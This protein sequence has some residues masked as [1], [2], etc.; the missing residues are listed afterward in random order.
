MRKAALDT[1]YGL[2]QKDSRVVFIGSDLGAGTLSE[3]AETLPDRFFMEGIAE[4]HLI[5]MAAGMALEGMIPYVNTIA[6]FLTR[7]C[8]EQ[9]A[10]DLCLHKLPVRLIANGGGLVYAPLGPTHQAI[11]DFALMRALP[12]MTCVAPADAVEMRKLMVNSLEWPGPVYFRLGKGGDP[13]ITPDDDS[14]EIGKAY[15]MEP[16]IGDILMIST[17]I[18][19]ER[20]L[21]ALKLSDQ[22]GL[23]VG[24]VHVPTI[25][26]LDV[27]RIT[28][29]SQK[30]RLVVTLEEH[31]SHGGLGSAVLETLSERMGRSMPRVV[32]LG[33]PDQYQEHYGS[34]DSLLDIA[35][36][37]PASI[38]SKL[39]S[40][41]QKI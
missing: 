37:Q 35:G 16:P 36:L 33:L 27:E 17:G 6:T 12:N 4:Q 22:Q 21:Q 28:D 40:L 41:A 29:W 38:A 26:P 25:K 1:V 13:V 9:V 8:F 18:M 7:R 34:Q 31:L 2:A 23:T 15:L 10:V 39:M 14:R 32:R 3:M 11:D 24:L 19:T 30:V 5:G 20:A